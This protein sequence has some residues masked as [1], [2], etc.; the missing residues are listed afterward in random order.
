MIRCTF[1]LSSVP[2]KFSD[3][4]V[5]IWRFPSKVRSI[6]VVGV[7]V[8]IWTVWNTRNGVVFDKVYPSSPVNMVSK[9][10]YWTTYW[11]C[12]Q[13]GNDRRAQVSATDC[14]LGWRTKPS[15][16]GKDGRHGGKDSIMVERNLQESLLTC[17]SFSAICCC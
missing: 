16:A 7:A 13:K 10:S 3:I 14:C 11:G 15:V 1:G 2:S 12:L 8:M 17:W 5:W 9:I 4:G 6:V